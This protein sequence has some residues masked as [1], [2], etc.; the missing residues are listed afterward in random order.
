M[1]KVATNEDF[2]EINNRRK[3]YLNIPDLTEIDIDEKVICVFDDASDAFILLSLADLGERTPQSSPFW[4]VLCFKAPLTRDVSV[5]SIIKRLAEE[6]KKRGYS[7]TQV[8][9]PPQKNLLR[10]TAVSL[11]MSPRTITINGRIFRQYTA[12]ETLEKI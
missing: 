1:I 3:T 5:R 7:E 11:L 12:K 4:I 6:L 8:V 9:W 10:E 2:F